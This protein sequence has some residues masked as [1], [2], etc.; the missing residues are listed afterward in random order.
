MCILYTKS[1]KEIKRD[2]QKL[3]DSTIQIRIN[4]H[5]LDASNIDI[6]TKLAKMRSYYQ[7]KLMLMILIPKKY[8]VVANI[9]YPFTLSIKLDV[10][11]GTLIFY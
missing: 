8:S 10:P 1:I 9:F 4:K 6:W 2:N 11:Y 3:L 7:R 5:Q